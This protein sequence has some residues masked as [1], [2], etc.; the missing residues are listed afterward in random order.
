MR[1]RF[2]F[3]PDEASA[4]DTFGAMYFLLREAVQSDF[5]LLQEAAPA[6]P[7]PCGYVGRSEAF[8]DAMEAWRDS[9]CGVP[10]WTSVAEF[11][12]HLTEPVAV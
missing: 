1:E 12:R 10:R 9:L 7:D 2:G 4:L 11:D 5:G 3:D 6:A 8:Q